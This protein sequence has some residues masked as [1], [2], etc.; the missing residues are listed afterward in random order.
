MQ[1]TTARLSGLSAKCELDS[2][3]VPVVESG[4]VCV[5]KSRMCRTLHRECHHGLSRYYLN[6]LIGAFRSSEG[7]V[8]AR[9]HGCNI[10]LVSQARPF[11]SLRVKSGLQ[12]TGQVDGA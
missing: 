3:P 10:S 12:G 11:L 4:S 7:H 2:I 8:H 6:N 1:A 5:E 9:G